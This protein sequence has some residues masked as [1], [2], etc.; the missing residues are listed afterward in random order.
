MSSSHTKDDILGR[1]VGSILSEQI[2]EGFEARCL[3]QARST[4]SQRALSSPVEKQA[5][6]SRSRFRKIAFSGSAAALFLILLLPVFFQSKVAFSQVWEALEQ[7]DAMRIEILVQNSSTPDRIQYSRGQGY[8]LDSTDRTEIDNG[9]FRWEHDKGQNR[10]LKYPSKLK[11]QGYTNLQLLS[12]AIG[13]PLGTGLTEDFSRRPDADQMLNGEPLKCYAWSVELG[14]MTCEQLVFIDPS[15]KPRLIISRKRNGHDDEW[16]TETQ[17]AISFA[18]IPARNFVV[19]F[20]SSLEIVEAAANQIA[21]DGKA[22][23]EEVYATHQ[24]IMDQWSAYFG[25]RFELQVKVKRQPGPDDDLGKQVSTRAYSAEAVD[26]RDQFSVLPPLEENQRPRRFWKRFGIDQEGNE[27]LVAA[28][29]YDGNVTREYRLDDR[30]R[31]LGSVVDFEELRPQDDSPNYFDGLLFCRLNLIDDSRPVS[32]ELSTL[33]LERM[34]QSGTHQREKWIEREIRAVRQSASGGME[35]RLSIAD[36]PYNHIVG[37]ELRFSPAAG[38]RMLGLLDLH[39]ADQFEGI[40][41]PS[42][43]RYLQTGVGFMDDVDY[44]FRV[45]RV[46]RLADDAAKTWWIEWPVG[47]M[48]NDQVM[49]RNYTI[50][51]DPF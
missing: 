5:R 49:K 50:G 26:Y 18:P 23:D 31:A 7:V 21:I 41:Y 43:G 8:R 45:T 14:R 25:L 4:L 34:H 27:V 13:F 20:A 40:W 15:K 32:S 22:I 46:S 2:P 35:W 30:G 11:Q 39:D 38:G 48:I 51:R 16:T 17:I 36:E 33:N 19:N 6:A 9:E 42:S 47:T 10:V 3:N 24:K 1:A 12:E 29:A 44:R 37:Y 28:L